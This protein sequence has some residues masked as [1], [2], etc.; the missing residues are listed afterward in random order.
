MSA[1][2]AQYSNMIRTSKGTVRAICYC[3]GKTSKPGRPDHDGEP[4]LCRLGRGWS[5]AG[6]PADFKH[7]DDG[8]VGSTFTCP[9]CNKLL[10][11]GHRLQVR[12]YAPIEATPQA[13][14]TE[15]L[16]KSH[17]QALPPN[18]PLHVRAQLAN[19][20]VGLASDRM[21]QLLTVPTKWQQA[22]QELIDLKA[23]TAVLENIIQHMSLQTSE[24]AA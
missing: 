9:A 2:T 24:E 8:S 5:M 12:N 1:Q 23:A 18:T 10:N 11:A 7:S 4:N 19:A 16:E 14:A 13:D 17:R 3:C 20:E 6:Y 22:R 21:A 15:H